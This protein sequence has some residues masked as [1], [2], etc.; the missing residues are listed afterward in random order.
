MPELQINYPYRI[1]INSI[2]SAVYIIKNMCN[3]CENFM[4]CTGEMA[5][6]CNLVK[7]TIVKFANKNLKDISE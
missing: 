6:K 2:E 1:K 3:N 4:M 7:E 5:E